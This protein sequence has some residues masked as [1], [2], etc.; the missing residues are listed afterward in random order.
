MDGGEFF[1]FAVIALENFLLKILGIRAGIM[2]SALQAHLDTAHV[3]V[4]ALLFDLPATGG[5]IA[6]VIIEVVADA[7]I[8]EPFGATFEQR[9]L[10]RRC[11]GTVTMAVLGIP[12][13]GPIVGIEE[14]G[15]AA[16]AAGRYEG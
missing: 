8:Q 5:E 3:Q 2:F 15:Q 13:G 6:Q 12:G 9:W 11:C 14:L 4:A 7:V 10:G 16:V 1:H